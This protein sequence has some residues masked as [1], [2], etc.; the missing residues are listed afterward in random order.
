MNEAL[1]DIESEKEILGRIQNYAYTFSKYTYRSALAQFYLANKWADR[2][3]QLGFSSTLLSVIAGTS[4][5]SGSQFSLRIFQFSIKNE[6]L[7]GLFALAA[8]A[9]IAGSTFLNPNRR[10]QDHYNAATSFLDISDKARFLSEVESRMRKKTNEQLKDELFELI[11]Q[12]GELT[13][14]SPRIPTKEW[15]DAK[16]GVQKHFER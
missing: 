4:L 14:D 1:A 15:D 2:H 11:K 16:D 8:S 9:L 13:K 10:S 3:L 6:T 5:L 12:R 7:A